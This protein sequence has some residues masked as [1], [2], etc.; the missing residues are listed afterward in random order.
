ME[1]TS[2]RAH[3]SANETVLKPQASVSRQ[4]AAPLHDQ[5]KSVITEMISREGLEPGD[6]LPSEH[7]L[8]KDLGV[9]RTVVRQALAQLENSG[10]VYRERGKGTFVSARKTS[11]SFVN[12]LSGL[13]DDVV[14]RGGTV[15]SDVLEQRIVPADTVTAMQL[16]IEPGD[17]VM[18]LRRMRY[19]DGEPW[20]LSTSWLPEKFGHLVSDSNMQVESLYRI[21]ERAGIVA[22]SGRRSVESVAADEP[23]ARLLNVVEGSPVLK[24]SSLRRNH[25]GVPIDYFVAYHR[26]DRSRFEYALEPDESRARML[27]LNVGPGRGESL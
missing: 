16:E 24:L 10:V 5:V 26:G 21:L 12:S 25:S 7:R 4:A 11:E 3:G 18:V 6:A 14:R 20:A 1:K 27:V 9:S 8:C 19:V 13:Y 2:A 17:M 23:T 22:A 15:E